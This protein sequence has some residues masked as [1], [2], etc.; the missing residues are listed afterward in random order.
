MVVG[1]PFDNTLE[2][3][4]YDLPYAG[5]AYV[6]G[7]DGVL[8]QTSFGGYQRASLGWS[9]AALG[10]GVAIGAPS[11]MEGAELRCAVPRCEPG[12]PEQSR[13]AIPILLEPGGVRQLS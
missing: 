1:A 8:L 10:R 12:R 5:T 2:E 13:S 4:G 6:F 11:P 7:L 3:S 9:M